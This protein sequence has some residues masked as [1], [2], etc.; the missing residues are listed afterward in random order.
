[1]NSTAPGPSKEG[2]TLKL[3]L[4]LGCLT[5]LLV[6]V[7][8]QG[9]YTV[10]AQ[11]K[12]LIGGLEE[13]GR[14]LG[15]LMVNVV[16]PSLA[17]DDL[18][19]ATEGLGF[20]AKDADFAFSAALAPDGRVLSFVGPEAARP[21]LAA[22]ASA[23]K[24]PSLVVGREVLVALY[25]LKPGTTDLG[26]VAVGL[27]TSNV[28]AAANRMVARVVLIAAVGIMIA[29]LVVLLL[30]AAIVR[31]NRDLKLIMD[32]VGQ[33]FMSV[34]R[35]GEV[36]P[37]HSA[38]LESWF[39]AWQSGAPFWGYI[40]GASKKLESW[41][42]LMW[43]NVRSDVL[44]VEIA[45]EQLPVRAEVGGKTFEFQYKPIFKG[46]HLLHIMFVISDITALVEQEH[47]SSEQRELM[48]LFQWLLKDRTGLL[49]FFHDANGLVQQSA[50]W[51]DDDLGA[52]K[53]NIHTLKGNASVFRLES[54][55][56]VCEAIENR[57][58]D[59][60]DGRLSDD[61]IAVLLATWKGV[62]DRMLRLLDGDDARRLEIELHEH[63]ELIAAIERQ[64]PHAALFEIARAWTFEPMKQ[65]LGRY[66]K[67]AGE[68][69]R[70]LNKG[71]LTVRV[72]ADGVRLP[73]GMLAPFWSS[74]AHLIRNAVDHGIETPDERRDAGKDGPAVLVL[75]ASRQD[76]GLVVAIEDNGRGI[77]WDKL[78][79]KARAAGLPSSSR[80]DLVA[81]LFA[82]GITTREGATEVSGRGVGMS[83]VREACEATGGRL[84][85]WSEPGKGTRFEFAW[86][87][88][89]LE[90]ARDHE[91]TKAA[92]SATGA[93]RSG[94]EARPG[95]G[96]VA[97]KKVAA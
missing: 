19:G 48:S 67:Q 46:A 71:E 63:D 12:A 32:N 20:I 6:A 25:P 1:M 58:A 2:R 28:R 65:R 95:T 43:D 50:T 89:L 38:I 21:L 92:A 90:P 82:D 44:P 39:G 14:S 31:R 35:G 7:I 94:S 49:E 36:L 91:V 8:C 77:S 62:Q 57:W 84:S 23:V 11:R 54:V 55:T 51:G 66:G 68:L 42:E 60:A 16:G 59:G 34:K 88:T 3:K 64:E 13:K 79:E 56:R 24:A 40:G 17:L 18:P 78:A 70:R 81:A 69:A 73:Q 29:V 85:V 10:T 74:A 86:P 47:A 27:K 45:L 76:E 5:P 30:A 72:E 96:K 26:T 52:L 87:R 4:L 61:E 75:H 33:G 37:E 9:L 83:A 97:P 41:F 22:S 80:E 15:A 53:R 93:P